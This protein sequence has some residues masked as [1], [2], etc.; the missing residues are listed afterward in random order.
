MRKRDFLN[1]IDAGRN[2][3]DAQAALAEANGNL[4]KA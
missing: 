2:R 1:L 4:A 3:A